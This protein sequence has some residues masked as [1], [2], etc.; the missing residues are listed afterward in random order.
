VVVDTS[1]IMAVLLDEPQRPA[2]EAALNNGSASISAVTLVELL[3]VAEGRAGAEGARIAEA[4][5]ERFAIDVVPVDTTQAREAIPGWRRFGSGRHPAS[6]NLG[7]CFSYAAAILR[8]E[9]LLFVGNNFAQT[10]VVPALK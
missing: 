1:A 3:I 7:D 6:L 9:Q 10:D 5:L 2:I 4:L 8:G